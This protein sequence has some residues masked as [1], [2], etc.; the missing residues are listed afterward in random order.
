LQPSSAGMP[1]RLQEVLPIPGACE[2]QDPGLK[3]PRGQPR[4]IV[5]SPHF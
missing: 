3:E 5:L 1:S 2:K 4:I